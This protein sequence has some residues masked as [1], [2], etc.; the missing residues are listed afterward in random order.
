MGSA[1]PPFGLIRRR[2]VRASRTV[3]FGDVD[4]ECLGEMSA[5]ALGFGR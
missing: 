4:A 3:G 1:T 5:H 2:G